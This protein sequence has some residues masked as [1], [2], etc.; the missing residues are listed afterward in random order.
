MV[1]GYFGPQIY[2]KEWAPPLYVSETNP[3]L[4]KLANLIPS[5]IVQDADLSRQIHVPRRFDEGGESLVV[6]MVQ[7]QIQE[8]E[9]QLKRWK[10]LIL[11]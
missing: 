7:Q 11:R 10:E 9:K 2:V 4:Y 1:F 6:D 8:V 3:L 5:F